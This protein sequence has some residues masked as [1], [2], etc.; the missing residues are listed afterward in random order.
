LIWGQ[1]NAAIRELPLGPRLSVICFVDAQGISLM[2]QSSGP[3]KKKPVAESRPPSSASA[4]PSPSPPAQHRSQVEIDDSKAVT[5]YANFCRVTGTPEE[6]ILD[7]GLNSNP[8]TA[9]GE[10]V[11]EVQ[12]RLVINHFTAKR[13]LQALAMSVERHEQAFGVLETD[14]QKRVVPQRAPLTAASAS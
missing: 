11:I 8:M 3:E 2:S 14:I 7:F 5:C 6:L 13:M 9:P 4:Q 12:Q 10:R 1:S